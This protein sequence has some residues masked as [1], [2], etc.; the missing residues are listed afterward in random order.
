[1]EKRRFTWWALLGL[2]TIQ[3]RRLLSL[4]S[5]EFWGNFRPFFWSIRGHFVFFFMDVKPVSTCFRHIFLIFN[6]KNSRFNFYFYDTILRS[7]TGHWAAP[8]LAPNE[9]TLSSCVVIER[10]YLTKTRCFCFYC[11]NISKKI[12]SAAP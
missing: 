8:G 3:V 11:G 2:C 12:L 7:F 1:M 6:K 5:R 10:F 4:H 9:F